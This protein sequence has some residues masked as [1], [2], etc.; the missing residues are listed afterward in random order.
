[1]TETNKTALGVDYRRCPRELLIEM[2]GGLQSC[3]YWFIREN[4]VYHAFYL[5]AEHFSGTSNIGHL[6]SSDFLNWEY[7][8]TALYG[9]E[10]GIW[11]ERHLATGSV[12]KH[13][14]K[15]YMLYTGHSA[16]RPGLGIAVS[17]D[18]YQWQKVGDG[19][20]IKTGISYDVMHD[21]VM[22]KVQPLAD[23][24]MLPMPID[25]WYYAYVNSWVA[26]LPRNSRGSQL[27]FRSRD[28]LCWEPYRLAIHTP[29]IDRLETAQVWEHNGKWYMYF[30]G[31]R[32]SP[33]GGAFDDVE[34]HS[35]IYTAD[36]FD[37]P[38]LPQ[39]WSI[40]EYQTARYC[41][42]QK[43]LADPFGDD[44]ALVMTPYDGV[45]WPQKVIYAPDGAVSLIPN[46]L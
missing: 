4:G 15:Y 1:M 8:G 26:D 37:G 18:L 28:L 27:M 19:P 16:L 2:P 5:E 44:V 10:E 42:I 29:D 43:V 3:D 38:F 6:V 40:I 17:D 23:P 13:D 9:Q 36:S 46:R 33:D 41:Y 21:G 35:Y 25:G 45:L 30:G 14:G 32:V 12:V 24:Y 20:V 31:R 11:P 39:P 22:H 7:V 34:S